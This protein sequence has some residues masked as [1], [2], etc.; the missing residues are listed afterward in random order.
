MKNI[1]IIGGTRNMG[2]ALTRQLAEAGHQVTILNR[3]RNAEDLPDSIHRLRADRTDAQQM[4]RALQGK[5]F[6]MVI[7]FV[8]FNERE[9]QT[10]VELLRGNVG[11]YIFIS[12]G[13]VYLVRENITRPFTE[14]SYD[15]LLIPPPRPNTYAYEEWRYGMDKR[16]AE[17]TFARAHAEQGFPCTSLRLPMVNSERDPMRRLYSYVLRLK[18]GGPLLIPETPS[19]PLRHIYAGDVVRVIRQLVDT[20]AG[21]GKAYNISQ[22]ETL[23]IDEFLNHVGN[24]LGVEPK[25]KRFRQLEL[26]ANGFLPDC[27]PFSDNWMSELDN[28]LSKTELGVT[29]TPFTTYLAKIIAHYETMRPATPVGYKRRNAEIQFAQANTLPA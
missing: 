1:L 17:D 26:E 9:A 22:D 20:G 13:Q 18:D 15:G 14:A 10:M 25:I 12:S 16:G 6:H 5:S 3:G 7:D 4:R 21:I 23:T 29:Y 27:S 24:L 2:Y 19:Y 11:Q 28:T 8:M